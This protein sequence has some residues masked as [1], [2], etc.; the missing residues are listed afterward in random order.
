MISVRCP[1]SHLSPFR[2]LLQTQ[3][4]LRLR[5][6]GGHWKKRHIASHMAQ[7][8]YYKYHVLCTDRAISVMTGVTNPW[9]GG[10][11]SAGFCVNLLTERDVCP[12][13]AENN[14]LI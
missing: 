1:Q 6:A 12:A 3:S 5:K 13:G 2:S 4:G 11:T 7:T 14:C 10:L 9:A 8:I